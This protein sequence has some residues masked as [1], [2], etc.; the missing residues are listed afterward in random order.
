M[1]NFF[2]D[3]WG[4]TTGFVEDFVSDP[5]G[6][7]WSGVERLGDWIENWEPDTDIENIIDDL[8]DWARGAVDGGDVYD[9]TR[10]LA[11]LN[12]Q[13]IAVEAAENKRRAVLQ[14]D[15]L[16]K[17]VIGI[18][19]SS[20][21]LANKGTSKDYVEK[22]KSSFKAE[23]D[24]IDTSTKSRVEIAILEGEVQ[25]EI[26]EASAQAGQVGIITDIVGLFG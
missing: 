21:F 10:R 4:E 26:G 12:A 18:Q 20:G 1:P 23:L 22:M 3:P 19:A 15:D 11:G 16:V 13:F 24:Y 25:A 2:D 17:Q 8:G 7:T 14:H 5:F 9:D 6:T